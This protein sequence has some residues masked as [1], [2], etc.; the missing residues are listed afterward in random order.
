MD[1]EQMLERA[2]LNQLQDENNR[3][4]KELRDVDRE[5]DLFRHLKDIVETQKP[6]TIYKSSQLIPKKQTKIKETAMLLLSDSHADQQILSKRVQGLEDYN[7]D[8]A[9][10]RAERLVD[11]TISHLF[12][13]MKNYQFDHLIIAGLGDYSSG[14][15]H[16]LQNYSKWGNAIKSSIGIGELLACMIADFSRYFKQITVYSVPGNHARRS[17]KK[18]YH[19]AHNNW[20]YLTMIHAATRLKPLIDEK[21]LRFVIP[22]A[23][24]CEVDVYNYS[25]ILNHGDD[26]QGWGG[27][28]LPYYGIERKTRRLIAVGAVKNKVPNYFLYGHFHTETKHQHTT[29]ETIINGAWTATDEFA[30]EKLGAYSEPSQ[31]LFGIHPKYGISWRMPVKLRVHNWKEEEQKVGRYEINIFESVKE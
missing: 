21:R 1:E 2:R 26:I 31:L 25:F 14:E 28:S 10:R 11:T 29:G 17:L 18:D 4:R 24:S 8:V 23:F 19:G 6:I 3:L 7:F 27:S 9:C 16:N 22:D 15:I 12:D 30:L 13:N 5:T 20:D